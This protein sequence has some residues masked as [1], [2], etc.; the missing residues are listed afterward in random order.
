MTAGGI[1]LHQ[2]DPDQADQIAMRLGGRH[3]RRLG[4]Q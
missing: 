4:Q 2:P 1:L 3:A